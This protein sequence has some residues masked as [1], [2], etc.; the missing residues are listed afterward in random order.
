MEVTFWLVLAVIFIVAEAVTV[1]VVSL[2]FAG[3]AFAAMA[4]AMLGGQLWLQG[5]VFGG[6]SALLLWAL[7]PLVRKH[8]TPKLTKTNLDAV[9]GKTGIV[10]A[11]IDN[12][13]ACGTVKLGSMEWSARST[14]G[15][16]I[17]AGAQIRVD[18][19][20]GVK[21]FVTAL[22]VSEQHHQEVIV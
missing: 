19:I 16:P 20:E 12:V 2:W 17:E 8:F 5:T 11:R 18:R 6:V 21:V 10:T 4:V 15:A 3:G 13:N 1:S 14:D 9:I 22:E 7:R